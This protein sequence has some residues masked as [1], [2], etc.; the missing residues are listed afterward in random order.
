MAP[1]WKK[2]YIWPTFHIFSY[3]GEVTKVPLTYIS[4]T[5]I[6]FV[7]PIDF[8]ALTILKKK[9]EFIRNGFSLVWFQ[10]LILISAIMDQSINNKMVSKI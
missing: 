5:Y 3:R 8:F 9:Y 4:L 1:I 2:G 6:Y 7:H 10:V